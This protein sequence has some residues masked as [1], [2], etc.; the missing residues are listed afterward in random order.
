MYRLGPNCWLLVSICILE[1]LLI[2]KLGLSIE[3]VLFGTIA[4]FCLL[5]SFLI[6]AFSLRLPRSPL[7]SSHAPD[8]CVAAMASVRSF[9]YSF[10]CLLLPVAHSCVAGCS[11]AGQCLGH[12]P[13]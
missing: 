2:L 13:L 10:C 6:S 7:V 3:Q 11:L 5:E 1:W 12:T 4:C 8:Q 9:L